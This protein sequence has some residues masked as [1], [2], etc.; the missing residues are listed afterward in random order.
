MSQL[1]LRRGDAVRAVSSAALYR[2]SEMLVNE[3][4]KLLRRHKPSVSR[5]V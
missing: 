2:D 1:L 5:L 3:M 4:L